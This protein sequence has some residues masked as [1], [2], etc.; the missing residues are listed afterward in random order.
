MTRKIKSLHEILACQ[1]EGLYD[2][3]KKLQH[4]L[5]SRQSAIEGFALKEELQKFESHSSDARMKLKRIFSYLLMEPFKIKN[6]IISG[7]IKDLD[8]MTSCISDAHDREMFT[9][10]SIHSI[11]AY[12]VSAYSTALE[13]S[14]KLALD[15][16]SDLLNE[17][18]AAAI[19][20][21]TKLQKMQA[22]LS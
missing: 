14:H 11:N 15:Q 16:V 22:L 18:I 20:C 6:N 21:D 19:A 12:K 8:I 4:Y 2:G 5:H 7:F 10:N 13:L 9:R 1:L 17:I 3:E